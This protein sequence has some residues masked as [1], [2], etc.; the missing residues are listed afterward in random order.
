MD[1]T[2]LLEYQKVDLEFKK[3][4]DEIVRNKDYKTMKAKKDEFNAAK[5]AVGES[6][7]LAESVMNAYNGALEYLK[8]NAA[9]V[10]EIVTK[11]TAGTLDED[12]EKAAVEELEA[13]KA[14]LAEWEKKA[15]ALKNNADKAIA[16]FSEAQK[17]GKAARAIYADAKAKYEEFKKGKEKEY[18][19]LKAKLAELQKNVEPKVF[20]VYKQITAENKYPAFVPAMGDDASPA[21][22][23]CGMGLSG[24]AKND[25]K[26][27]GYCRCETCRRIIY[28]QG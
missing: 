25:L 28:K 19:T 1:F 9:K 22:G 12:A 5:Q 2:K 4:N 15:A 20:E 11:L 24:T 6:E 14:A 7:A 10:E 21:C 17:T 13:L 16:D 26:N 23:A 18:E 3:L 27:Q 8:T